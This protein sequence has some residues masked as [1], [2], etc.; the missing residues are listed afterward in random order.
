MKTKSLFYTSCL[1]V[2]ALLTPGCSGCWKKLEPA[3]VNP[4]KYLDVPEGQQAEIWELI[5][6]KNDVAGYRHTVVERFTDAGETVYQVTQEDVISATRQGEKMTGHIKTVVLQNRDGVFLEGKKTENLSDAPMVTVILP[7][8]TPGAMLRQ[9]GT[10]TINPETREEE[11]NFK[12]SDKKIPMK[13]GTP[14]PFAKQFSLWE[15]PLQPGEKR[16]IEFFDLSLEQMGVV[17][18]VAGKVAPLLYYNVETNLLP[19]VE[20]TQI[21][22]YTVILNHWMDAGGNIVRTT[23]AEPQPMEI[24]LSTQEK[25]LG[26]FQNAGNVN[27]S[28]FA[29]VRVQGAIPQPRLTHKVELRLHRIDNA[30]ASQ[31][32]FAALFP[33]TA[34][35]TVKTVDENTLDMTVTASSPEAMSALYGRVVPPAPQE[36]TVPA[37]L[38]RN[39]WI[40]SDAESVVKLAKAATERSYPPWDV[41]VDL[42]RFVSQQMQRSHR[43]SFAAAAEVAETLQGDSAGSAVLLAAIARARN[44]PSRVVVGLTYTDTPSNEGVFIPHFWTEL[45]LDGHWHPFDATQGRGGAD[46]SRI[47]LARSNLADESLPAMA[48]KILPLIGHVQV[49]II[50]PRN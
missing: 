23:L 1:L 25:T 14:G 30:Q 39:E 38:Q 26:A 2:L 15:K 22:E 16:T 8:E 37:D 10:V 36:T 28:L 50:V 5:R 9:A 21:G 40:Q 11:L 18:L 31:Q 44:I 45:Y 41:A 46:A 43:Q 7:D 48:A 32:N 4:T 12:P 20:T 29:L 24:M 17:E 13:P 3:L 35:Q 47:V 34:F 33:T 27:L 49:E 42:E 6:V 19:V